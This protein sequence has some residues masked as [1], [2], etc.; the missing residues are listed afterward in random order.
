M[1][2]RFRD[3]PIISIALV[4]IN[5]IVFLVSLFTA[6]RLYYYG[7]SKVGVLYYK[8]YG[9]IL[10]A[11]FLHDDTAHLFGNMI[12]LLFLG[13]MLEK[14]VGH[15]WF[16]IVYFLSGIAG[17]LVSLCE[18]VVTGV[19]SLSIGASGA[20][21]GLDGLLLALVFCSN[22]FRNE[23]QPGKV[24]L[25]VGLSL[26]D[27]FTRANVGNEAHVGGLIV[28]FLLG[29]LICLIQN[30]CNKQHKREVQI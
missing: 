27:G 20:V 22:R 23:V 29:L 21:F 2:R 26:Y 5:I 7:L 1:Q 10:W 24:V 14:E 9:N 6:G 16:T 4:T 8:Q 19:D 28:G 18:K 12:V 11:M 15:I 3:L 13:S 30:L 17:N 25:V